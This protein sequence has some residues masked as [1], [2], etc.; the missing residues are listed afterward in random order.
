MFI[1]AGQETDQSPLAIS[2]VIA[3][4]SLTFAPLEPITG[5]L[6]DRFSRKNLMVVSNIF[7]FVTLTSFILLD[8]L[9]SLFSVY[10]LTMLLV[11][12]RA[13]YDPSQ[14]GYLPRVC[15]EN[16]LL[17]ANALNSGAWSASLGIG[18]GI[19]GVM[20]SAYGIETGLMIDSVTFLVAAIVIS[21]LPQGGPDPDEER[22]SGLVEMFKDIISG[23]GF[24]FDRPEI[25]RIVIAKSLWAI[26]GGSQIFLLIIIGMEADFGDISTG[27]AGIGVLY[28]ARGF[29]SGVGPIVTRPLMSVTKYMPYIIGLSLGG[30]G[31][32]YLGVSQVEW[33]IWTLIFVFFSHGCS[34]ISWVFSTT[35]LQQRTDNN[36]MGRV[37]GT[38]NLLIVLTMGTSTI[39]AGYILEEELMTLREILL[40]TG[41]IQVAVGV[42]WLLLASPREKIFFASQNLGQAK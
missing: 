13:L 41:L 35:L 36:W 22:G 11:I 8:L 4:R 18:S 21:T 39:S 2:G 10:I 3:V 38:D 17:T 24:I 32:L 9:D 30:A 28:M 34:G 29:G 12:G 26:G 20:I 14:Q 6:A 19:A 1:L 40:V 25:S 16:E 31:L 42:L 27:A 5:Y 37:A 15:D 33:G 23:W 7:S